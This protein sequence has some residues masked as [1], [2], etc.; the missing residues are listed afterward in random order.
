LRLW[1]CVQAEHQQCGVVF[2][3]LHFHLIILTC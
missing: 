2:L 1:G 3:V